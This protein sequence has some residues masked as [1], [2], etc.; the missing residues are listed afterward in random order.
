MVHEDIQQLPT[1]ARELRKFGL[2]V[3]GVFLLL[4]AYCL[5]RHRAAWPW[6]V[7]PGA[8]LVFLG[9]LAPLSLKQIYVGWMALAFTL[10]VGVSTVLL[11]QGIRIGPR[12]DSFLLHDE[13]EE[14]SFRPL[15]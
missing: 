6:L 3:G 2:M 11:T 8:L 10:G 14:M 1:G 15:V 13:L 12:A 9:L 4:G 5:W 7:T